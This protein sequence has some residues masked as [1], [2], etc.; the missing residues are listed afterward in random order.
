VQNISERLT[1]DLIR[2]LAGN[3]EVLSWRERHEL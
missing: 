1:L 2:R 3:I